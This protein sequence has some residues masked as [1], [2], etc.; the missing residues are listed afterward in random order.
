[1]LIFNKLELPDPGRKNELISDIS[2]STH[3]NIEKVVIKKIDLN[4]GNAELEIFL[5]NRDLKD[6]Q[7]S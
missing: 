5:R 1:M 6:D 4:M 3:I 2:L 7:Q